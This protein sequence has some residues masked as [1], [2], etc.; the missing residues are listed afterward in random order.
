MPEQQHDCPPHILDILR[1]NDTYPISV[2]TAPSAQQRVWILTLSHSHRVVVRQWLSGRG[3]WNLNYGG[4]LQS[5][6]RSELQGYRDARTALPHVHIPHVLQFHEDDDSCWAVLEFVDSYSHPEQQMG[7]VRHEFG[8]DEPH[9]RWGRLPVD[10]SLAYA[11]KILETIVVPLHRVPAPEEGYRYRDM[12]ELY[13]KTHATILVPAAAASSERAPRAAVKLLERAIHRLEQEAVECGLM[14]KETTSSDN[15]LLLPCVLCH[16]DLQP[17]NILFDE[18]DAILSVLDWEDAAT[19]DPRFELLLLCRK[20]LANRQQADHLWQLYS[21]LTCTKLGPLDPWLRLETVHSL[22]TLCLQA[23]AGGGR[24]PWE[25]Q[26]DLWGKVDRE[27]QRLVLAG[28]T[29]CKTF[30]EDYECS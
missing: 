12:V 3:W 23:C 14:E 1:T 30:K 9:P 17:Q 22:T 10:Q 29:F 6:A 26:K 24:S 16:M 7:R 21:D 20:V 27:F 8:F 2:Q 5:V 19:A 25:D 18:N 13:R 11:H 28:W 15:A 4:S